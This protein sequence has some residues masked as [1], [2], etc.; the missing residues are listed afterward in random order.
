[1]DEVAAGADDEWPGAA[2]DLFDP[3]PLHAVSAADAVSATATAR[4]RP[5]LIITGSSSRPRASSRA[6]TRYRVWVRPDRPVCFVCPRRQPLRS[7]RRRRE[8]ADRSPPSSSGLGRRP[9]KAEHGFE[10]RWGY[11]KGF[12][13]RWH[14]VCTARPGPVVK[15]GVHAALSRRRSRVRSR[16]D[17]SHVS[18]TSPKPLPIGQR[19]SASLR[20]AS[21]RPG[22]TCNDLGMSE[23]ASTSITF[24]QLES[25]PGFFATRRPREGVPRR[26]RSC[27]SP[28][29]GPRWCTLISVDDHLVEPP[30][31]FEG[32]MPAKYADAAPRVEARRR[33]H[34]VLELR[35]QAALQGR[36][37]RGR[38]A[39]AGRAAASS[40]PAS[41]RCAAA[42]GT[43]TPACATW[44]STASTRR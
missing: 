5:P 34:G 17:R 25:R 37:Q 13:V 8:V 10:S 22:H 19:S 12:S 42:R 6:G 27:P 3:E 39:A 15:P 28:S 9:F 18:C 20:P 33:R 31:L 30:H 40:R 16:Q 38:R 41:T 4:R 11:G 29:A 21:A 44:T 14:D 2:L 36:A 7:R 43:S 24:D 35:R 23:P 1:M 26:S 32:R